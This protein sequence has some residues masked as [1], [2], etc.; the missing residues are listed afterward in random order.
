MRCTPPHPPVVPEL[1]CLAQGMTPHG[2]SCST[3]RALVGLAMTTHP[4]RSHFGRS[5]NV[6]AVSE[7]AFFFHR[8]D[9]RTIGPP[10]LSNPLTR[11][12]KLEKGRSRVQKHSSHSFCFNARF[13]F[14][15][16][17]LHSRSAWKN[18]LGSDFSHSRLHYCLSL[19]NLIPQAAQSWKHSIK[20]A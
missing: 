10:W 7:R 5:A 13:F 4:V 3:Y 18:N 19:K 2:L 8:A 15:L 11:I 6:V 17:F 12:N 9:E 1:I 20:W 14:P 16:F